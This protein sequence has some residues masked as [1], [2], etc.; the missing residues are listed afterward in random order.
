MYWFKVRVCGRSFAGVAGS[1][2]VR[3]RVVCVFSGVCVIKYMSLR[4]ADHSSRGVLTSVVCLSVI[5]YP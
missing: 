3:S 1:N 4:R 2:P 5:V